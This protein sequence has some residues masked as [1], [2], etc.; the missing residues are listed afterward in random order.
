MKLHWIKIDNSSHILKIIRDSAPTEEIILETKSY[1]IHDLMH[2]CVESIGDFQNAFWGSL[3]NGKTLSEMSDQKNPNS[4]PEL[5][6]VE[7]IVGP[8]QSLWK[9]RIDEE[10]VFERLLEISILSDPSLFIKTIHSKM[11]EVWGKWQSTKFGETMEL[12]WPSLPSNGLRPKKPQ[13]NI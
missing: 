13:K 11:D 2:Y 6:I 1:L 3:E 9:K 12:V 10:I 5:Q 4:D 7:L 8:M